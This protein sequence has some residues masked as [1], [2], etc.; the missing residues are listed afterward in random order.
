MTLRFAGGAIGSYTA[1]YPELDLPPEENAMRMYGDR[2]VMVIANRR[3]VVQRPGRPTEEHR[4]VAGDGGYYN[5]FRNFY[6]AVAHGEPLVGTIAQSY[7]NMPII[8]R[9]LESAERGATL[10]LD[11]AP[12]GLTAASVPLW[13]SRG[14]TGLLEGLPGQIVTATIAG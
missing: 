7:H 5:E 9:G 6:D 2:G 13:R 10:T 1:A 4:L 11:D 12:G 14:A 8:A 3:V